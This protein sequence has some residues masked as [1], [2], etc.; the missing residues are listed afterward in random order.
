MAH[1]ALLRV[2]TTISQNFGPISRWL[3]PHV[4]DLREDDGCIRPHID[5]V[6]FSGGIVAGLSLLSRC[7][8]TLA[9][10]DEKSGEVKPN[11]DSHRLQL[12]PNSL[13]VL[14]G[15]ARFSYAHSISETQG[16]RLSII[17]RDELLEK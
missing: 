6:K 14:S 10:A 4:I 11:A 13:Y 16:R 17:F 15:L 3:P 8:M 5:S 12:E 1:S 2:R 7:T 9:R